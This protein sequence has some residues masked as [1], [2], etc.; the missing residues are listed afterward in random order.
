MARDLALLI[1]E[2]T[3][4]LAVV[5][6]LIAEMA[7]MSRLALWLGLAGLAAATLATLPLLGADTSV[8]SGTYRIDLLSGWAKLIL[9][10]GTALALL[11]ARAEIAGRD[12]EG[13]V[14]TLLCLVTLGALMLAGSGDMMLLVLGVVLT[15]LGSFA[16]VAYPRD[17]AATEAGMKY[18]VFG[19][20][21]G[22][23]MIYGLTF[24][25]GGAG[26]TLF[27]SLGALDGKPLIAIAGLVAVIVG[28]GYKA[29]L[30]P[31]HF[32]APDAYDG[33]PVSVAAYLSVITKPAAIFAFAQVLRDLPTGSGWPL[34]IALLSAATM[35]YGYLAALVQTNL[36]RLIAYSSIAQSGYFLLGIVALGVSP[37][38]IPA[39]IVMGAAYVAMNLGAFAIV[40]LAGR[41]LDDIRGFGRRRPVAGVA[42][43]VFLL[44][45]TGIPPLFGFVGKV[46]LFGA[47]IEAGYLWLAVIG[48]LNSVLGLGV[49]LRIVVPMY[50]TAPE[51]GPDLRRA[52]PALITA[53]AVAA[54]VT[55]VMGL[56]AGILPG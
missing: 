44:S 12:R 30:V 26:S 47:A 42:M 14:Y 45:L 27:S 25:F 39:L 46:Y 28:L 15:G 36:V 41:S 13:S 21:T 23:V 24:W 38:A 18:L 29:S 34:V 3:L 33:A 1:P 2:L 22:S 16:L 4:A 43:V 50:G 17:D 56:F 6:M 40:M 9:L 53:G 7:R 51:G 55:L 19:A 10:P 11:M 49:Y 8:F 32:W 52:H 35:T 20:V 5:F 31:F 48:I 37:L 54:A